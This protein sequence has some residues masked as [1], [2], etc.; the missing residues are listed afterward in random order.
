MAA[1]DQTLTSLIERSRDRSVPMAD[2]FDAF[3]RIVGRFQDLAFTCA[4]ARL[5]DPALAEDAAQDAFLMAWER[6]EQLRDPSA[7]PGWMQRLVRTQCHRR[8]RSR[9]LSLVP[10]DDARDVAVP[11]DIPVDG[12]AA[13]RST[14]V[15]A[16]LAQLAPADRL[17]LIL[18]Y[19]SERS[20]AE[21]ADWLQVPVTTVARRLAHAKRRLRRHTLNA[22]SDELRARQS[23]SG[24]SLRVE[25]SARLRRAD[26]GDDDGIASLMDRLNE[27]PPQRCVSTTPA[28]AYIVED[29]A[30]QAPLAY[31]A[32]V[33]TAFKPIYDLQISIGNDALKRHAGD[34]LMMQVVEDVVGRGAIA[35]QHRTTSRHAALVEF[36]T[37]RGF[38]IVNRAQDWRRAGARTVPVANASRYELRHLEALSTDPA[39]FVAAL[40]LLTDELRHDPSERAFLPIHPDALRRAL[41]RQQD[42]V[43]AIAGGVL[44]GMIAASTDPIV[45]NGVQIDTV[46]VRRKHRRQG[47]GSAL[48][49]RLLEQQGY[50]AARL[51]AKQSPDLTLWLVRCGFAQASD[52]LVLE[53]LLQKTVQVPPERL[54]EY[55][56]RYVVEMLPA[57]PIDIERHG[58]SLI[59]KARDMR[60]VL[61]ASSECEFFTRHHYGRGRFE[62]DGTGRVA[63]LVYLDGPNEFVAVRS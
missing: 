62:R 45:P 7:F 60:D 13:Y 43:I 52:T 18:F 9:R 33:Q 38:D 29:P 19:G 36:L 56:G 35:L 63:R 41:R 50:P 55:V 8:L 28:C 40:E 34:V 27:H 32:A 2:R 16:S 21:I 48:L 4:C 53:R 20:Q 11:A 26:A 5:R 24:E 44:Q 54:D 46:L 22:L 37:S 47:L 14:L 51:V 15:R 42:G 12:E 59:S 23:L 3:A 58:H 25:L 1:A 31:G 39:L 49:G 6:L 57:A 61:L 10:Q 17:V 30:A